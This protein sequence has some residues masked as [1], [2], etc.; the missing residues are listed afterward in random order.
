MRIIIITRL[1]DIHSR[2]LRFL[3]MSSLLALALTYILNAVNHLKD[4]TRRIV[5]PKLPHSGCLAAEAA[6]TR[7]ASVVLTAAGG[8]C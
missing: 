3:E 6:C 5:G 1:M 4:K 8:R 7:S 2:R